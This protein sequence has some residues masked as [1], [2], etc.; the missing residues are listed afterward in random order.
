MVDV[1]DKLR[2]NPYDEQAREEFADRLFHD[3]AFAAQLRSAVPHVAPPPAPPKPKGLIAMVETTV[4]AVADDIEGAVATAEKAVAAIPADVE[5]VVTGIEGEVQG[6]FGMPAR[7]ERVPWTNYVA[8]QA[9]QPLKIARPASLDQMKSVLADAAAIGCPVR[10]V[11]SGHAWSDSALTD[12]IVIETHALNKP[13]PIKAGL[14]KNGV[15]PN[16]LFQTE[17][18]IILTD[19]IQRLADRGLG[20]INMGGYAGQTLAGV[21]STS[22]HG[23]GITLGSFPAAVEALV[24][25]TAD[26]KVLQIEKSNGISDPAA[27]QQE[28]GNTIELHQDDDLFNACVVGVGC[29]GVIYAATIRVMPLYYLEERRVIKSWDEVKQ[30]LQN[31]ILQQYR[32]VEVLFNPHK[33]RGRNSCLLTTRKIVDKPAGTLPDRPQ[34]GNVYGTLVDKFVG[35]LLAAVFNLTPTLSPQ[36]ID[37]ALN[38]LKTDKYVN[39]YYKVLNIGG[40]NDYPAVCA[41]YAIEVGT[42]IDAMDAILKAAEH[43]QQFGIY[44]SSPAAM[45]WVAASPGYLSMQPVDT[46]M[47]ELPNLRGVYGYPDIYWRYEEMLTS[48][49]GARPHWGQMNFLS[50]SRDLVAA[51]YPNL[52]KWLNVYKTFNKNGRFQSIFTDRVGFSK[53]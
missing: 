32:H 53:R 5:G 9:A 21:I 31:G 11:G 27:F 2:K 29:L 41:E 34:S 44:H 1:F 48:Q 25:V 52:D 16:T 43:Y 6:L 7:T 46:C 35:E 26:G 30:D 12:G 42:Q 47:I 15:D 51:L 33:T 17:A 8:T 40:P 23:S 24:I 14:L 19:L 49:F 39:V 22:T 3:D 45:R 10:A 4:T 28:F 13:M 18:G 38:A 20:L 50:G 36:L 37:V